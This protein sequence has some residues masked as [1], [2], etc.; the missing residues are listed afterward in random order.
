MTTLP[1]FAKVGKHLLN[2]LSGIY[3]AAAAAR[4]VG[5]FWPTAQL[6]TFILLSVAFVLGDVSLILRERRSSEDSVAIGIIGVVPVLII[7]TAV[8]IFVGRLIGRYWGD[9]PMIGIIW[10]TMLSIS[11]VLLVIRD[12]VHKRQLDADLKEGHA[13]R[14]SKKVI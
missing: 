8:L 1:L 13:T 3:I 10:A 12:T 4:F 11:T 5:R 7:V 14:G 9:A 6:N 2:V